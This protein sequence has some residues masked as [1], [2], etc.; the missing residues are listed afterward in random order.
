MSDFQEARSFQSGQLGECIV[1]FVP[2]F[3]T[4]THG[5]GE[6]ALQLVQ[7]AREHIDLVRESFD[8]PL[9]NEARR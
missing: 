3:I 5:I 4:L 1:Q 6:L 2:C 7:T 8:L 9:E